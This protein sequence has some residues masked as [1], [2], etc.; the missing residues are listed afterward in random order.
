[1]TCFVFG[2]KLDQYELFWVALFQ[3]SALL[4]Y[5]AK[6]G[7]KSVIPSQDLDQGTLWAHNDKRLATFNVQHIQR[8]RS[9]NGTH[10]N[11]TTRALHSH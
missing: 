11:S 10:E 6:Y 2:A 1:M 5:L 3:H 9:L 7:A 8:I 4:Q